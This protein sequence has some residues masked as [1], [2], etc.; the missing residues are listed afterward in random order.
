MPIKHLRRRGEKHRGRLVGSGLKILKA[1]NAHILLDLFAP[2]EIG[3]LI[4][5][6]DPVGLLAK[7]GFQ[8]PANLIDFLHPRISPATPGSE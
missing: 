5:L 8:I 4:S 1:E 7:K 2:L 3:D 6:P